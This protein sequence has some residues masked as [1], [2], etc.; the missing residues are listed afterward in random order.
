M[1]KNIVKVIYDN[2]EENSFD[3]EQI[4]G[5]EEIRNSLPI[6]QNQ[7]WRVNK[8]Y[9]KQFKKFEKSILKGL[10]EETVK[11]YSKDYLDLKD[12]DE[13]DCDCED[14]NISDLDD[15]ELLV[16]LS[17]RKLL[18]FKN[19]NIINVDLF[20]RFSKIITVA[21]PLDLENIIVEL[22]KKY[23]L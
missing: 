14:L 22:E 21:N 23:N 5:K 1:S 9:K 15:E 16:E 6:D 2:G 8:A 7:D 10:D 18:G 4:K 13:N 20:T 17:S 19:L 12:E 3:V 11:D